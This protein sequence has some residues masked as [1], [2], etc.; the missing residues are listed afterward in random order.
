MEIISCLETEMM[1]HNAY[2]T[3]S[4][5]DMLKNQRP[6][7]HSA[8]NEKVA[9]ITKYGFV[10]QSFSLSIPKIP[11][12]SMD[13]IGALKKYALWLEKQKI[14]VLG[15]VATFCVFATITSGVQYLQRKAQPIEFTKYSLETEALLSQMNALVYKTEEDQF[16][17]EG[18]LSLSDGISHFTQAVTWS[19]Y[20]VSSGDNISS[21]SKKF[22]LTNI[23]TLIAVNNIDNVRLLRSGQELKIPS[24]DGL[25][26]IVKSGDTIDSIGK[27][28]GTPVVQILDVNELESAHLSV[29]EK[30]F[31]PGARL[32][33][34][35]LKKALGELFVS[36]L[37]VS[38]RFTSP[39]GYR[40]DPFTGVRSFHTGIDMAAPQGT[41]IKA[42]MS[43][44]VSA[45]GY[46]NVYGNYVIIRH[47]SG[48]QTLY[49]HLQS[50][51]VKMG[52]KLNQGQRIGA[53]GNT[54]Y[55]TGPH[56][57]FS[58]YKNGKTIDPTSVLKF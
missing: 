52:Q 55:S 45:V 46:T 2:V 44:T 33:S 50:Y 34:T 42:A 53:L 19:T 40:A 41:A 36:P 49:A 6:A 57:H 47:E 23:S 11:T 27:K 8:K 31:I 1:S 10:N 7:K 3:T 26:H 24:M 51:S 12:I 9:K 58:V 5:E 39:Y 38:W 35:S 15:I 25:F 4:L 14:F 32:D 13:F 18:N 16:D 17:A 43:G 28:Y 21:L 48:Y 20:T 29:G 54:G 30:L 22:G 37:S 56:L